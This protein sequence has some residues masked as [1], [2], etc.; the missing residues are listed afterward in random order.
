MNLE[1]VKISTESEIINSCR[2]IAVVGL[3]SSPDKPSYHVASSL[4]EEGY[5]IIPVN[6]T[7]KKIL[8]QVCYPD[9]SSIPESVDVVDIFRRSEDVMPIIE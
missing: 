5:K 6:P 8:G 1:G 7:M 3:S 4:K 9:L 2:V